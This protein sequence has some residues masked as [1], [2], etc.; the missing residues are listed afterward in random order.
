MI[1]IKQYVGD[2]I[3][4]SLFVAESRTIAELLLEKPS[5]A[6]FKRV[7]EEDNIMQKNSAKT[8]IRYARTIRLRIEP[9]GD[10]YLEFLVRANETCVKQL[11]MAAFLKQAPIAID[12]MRHK[13]S[14]AR[15]MF[16]ERLSDYAW[17]DF[18]DERIRSIPE[19]ANFSES[20]IKK[21]GNNMIKALVDAGYLNSARQKRLQAVYLDPDV[22]SWLVQNGHEKIAQVMEV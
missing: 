8:A 10:N 9:M 17:S 20:S 18:I 15:R 21:M 3:G 14:D 13:L 1:N 4:G 19:L 7:V 22:Q 11:L 2:I 5:D 12:F 6:E 16:E